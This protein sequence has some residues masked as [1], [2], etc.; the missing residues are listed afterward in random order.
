MLRNCLFYPHFEPAKPLGLS[1]DASSYGIGAALSHKLADGTEHPVA[2]A[3]RS[4]SP[5][6][7]NYAQLDKEGLAIIFGVKFTNICWDESLQFTQTTN[8]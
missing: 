4:L 3:S 8:H 7:L 6:E 5:A 1:C 2:Y